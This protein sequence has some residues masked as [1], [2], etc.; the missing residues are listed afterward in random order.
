MSSWPIPL[1]PNDL[2][3]PGRCHCCSRFTLVAPGPLITTKG[4]LQVAIPWCLF[5]FERANRMLHRAAL[6]G[7]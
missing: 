5:G 3:G 6:R 4:G 1:P 7:T 2:W